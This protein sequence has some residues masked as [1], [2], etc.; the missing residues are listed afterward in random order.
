MGYLYTYEE[1]DMTSFANQIKEQLIYQLHLDG[2]IDADTC[3]EILNHYAVTMVKKGWLGTM[4][5][6]ACGIKDNKGLAIMVARIIGHRE[7]TNAETQ[8][9]SE[10]QNC[11]ENDKKEADQEQENCQEEGEGNTQA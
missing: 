4:I 11:Q 7:K 5:D 1:C 8:E 6:K 9:G 3:E 10:E 2:V